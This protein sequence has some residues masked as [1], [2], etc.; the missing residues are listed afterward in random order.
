M[1]GGRDVEEVVTEVPVEE[2][3]R[4][5]T[6]SVGPVAPS[7]DEEM[8]ER[9]ANEIGMERLSRLQDHYLKDLRAASFID[10]RM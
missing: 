10:L 5:S 2:G 3:A 4:N 6:A 1:V 7:A 9:V 8:R